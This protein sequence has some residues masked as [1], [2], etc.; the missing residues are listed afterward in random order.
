M[1]EPKIAERTIS[2]LVVVITGNEPQYGDS[3]SPYRSGPKLVQ[4]FNELGR[5]D[6]YDQGFPSRHI[7]AED[8]IREFIRASKIAR[9]IEAAVDP[10]HFLDFRT[11]VDDAVTY[12]NKYLAYDGYALRR[13]GNQFRL[14]QLG[15]RLVQIDAAVN[16]LDPLSQEFIEEQ[17]EKCDRKIQENDYD[18]AITNARSLLES[19]LHDLEGRLVDEPPEH[20]GDLQKLYKRVQ[21]LLNLEPSRADIS[22]A[23]KQVLTGVTSIVTGIAPLRN[24]MGDSHAR[25]HRPQRH[26]AKLAVNAARTAADFLLETFEYQVR[27]GTIMSVQRVKVNE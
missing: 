25:S 6:V 5:D 1:S 24:K 19:V 4:F 22:N 2:A 18:G 20:D 3:L 21:K 13:S 9:V 15:G 27:Q 7:Y 11:S 23:L 26:H 12:L 17:I 8:C 10:R 14:G 16:S